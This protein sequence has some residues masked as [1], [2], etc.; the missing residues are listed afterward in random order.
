MIN[1]KIF[2]GG[3]DLVFHVRRAEPG[4]AVRDRLMV[5]ETSAR[6]TISKPHTFENPSLVVGYRVEEG[7]E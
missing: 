5:P 4:V 7:V 6:P 3:L 2:S 1:K